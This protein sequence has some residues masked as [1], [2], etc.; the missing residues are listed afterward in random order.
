M[1]RSPVYET[2]PVGGPPQADYLNGAVLLVT[3]LQAREIL[4]LGLSIERT[5]GR[6][7]GERNLPRTIDLDLLWIEGEEIDEPD[8]RV[9]HPR[10]SERAFAV[11][12]LIDLAPDAAHPRTGLVFATV[13]A[14]SEELR[15]FEG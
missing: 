4:E 1:K 5:L 3:S 7:R 2:S 10:L 13:A 9:P 6:E 12:P 15:R 8:L 11:R 14:A